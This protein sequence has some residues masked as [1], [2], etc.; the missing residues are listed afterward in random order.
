MDELHKHVKIHTN[1]HLIIGCQLVFRYFSDMNVYRWIGLLLVCVVKLQ[2]AWLPAQYGQATHVP[3]T[4]DSDTLELAFAGGLNNPQVYY[5]FRTDDG[6]YIFDREGD[7]LMV[8]S[9]HGNRWQ[10][11]CSRRRN[12]SRR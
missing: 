10:S 7:K 3:V 2:N 9:R 8:F 12:D 4:R 6:W 1:H 11:L 5:P